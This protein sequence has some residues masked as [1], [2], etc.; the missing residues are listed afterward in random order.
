MEF[1]TDWGVTI[2][3][4][5]LAFYFYNNQENDTNPIIYA[6]L[7]IICLALKLGNYAQIIA[8]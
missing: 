6:I 5:G 4:I 3:C 7:L 2:I 1:F 8:D